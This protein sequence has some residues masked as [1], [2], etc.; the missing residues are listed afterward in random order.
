MSDDLGQ[1]PAE[2]PTYG[3]I[4]LRGFEDRDVRMVMDMATDRH[5]PKI[6]TLP[7]RASRQEALAYIARQ[8]GRLAEGKGYSFCVADR[9]DDTALGGVG[10]W[11][12]DIDAGRATAGWGIAR[13]APADTGS[14]VRP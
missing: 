12:A 3:D 1:W 13:L 10:L 4:R 9:R 8:R 11:L 5:I 7:F 2:P 6:G 14:P